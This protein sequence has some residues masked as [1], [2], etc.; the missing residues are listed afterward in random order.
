[1]QRAVPIASLTVTGPESGRTGMNRP[2]QKSTSFHVR[3]VL[4]N[5]NHSLTATD[6]KKMTICIYTANDEHLNY[7]NRVLS[8]K[9]VARASSRTHHFVV[10]SF[11][12]NVTSST[13]STPNHSQLQGRRC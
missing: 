7:W 5:Y 9:D 3:N 2:K 10:A 13:F 11:C 4:D 8:K 6:G 12:V 1:V